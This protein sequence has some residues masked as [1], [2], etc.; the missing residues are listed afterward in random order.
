M[1]KE[2][3]QPTA[4]M[5]RYEFDVNVTAA[6]YSFPVAGWADP[7]VID[8][9]THNNGVC[10]DI[11]NVLVRGVNSCEKQGEIPGVVIDPNKP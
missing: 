5:V 10:Y 2:Y 9:C 4:K 6:K 3:R 1:K 7:G 8:V 11:Y